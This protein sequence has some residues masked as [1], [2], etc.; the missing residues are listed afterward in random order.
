MPSLKLLAAGDGPASNWASRIVMSE[1]IEIAETIVACGCE[2]D[3]NHYGILDPDSDEPLVIAV[4]ALDPTGVTRRWNGSG[5][6]EV[7]HEMDPVGYQFVELDDAMLADALRGVTAG[8]LLLRATTPKAKTHGVLVAAPTEG[9]H[10]AIVD[11]FDTTAV[12]DLIEVRPGPVTFVRHGGEWVE[13][14]KVLGRLQS[15]D[16]PRIVQIAPDMLAAVVAQVDEFDRANDDAITAAVWEE[17]KYKRSETGQ[18]AKKDGGSADGTRPSM[19]AE[20]LREY[21]RTGKIP[22]DVK[23]AKSLQESAKTKKLNIGGGKVEKAKGGSGGSGGGGKGKGKGGAGGKATGAE[24]AKKAAK[25]GALEGS[26]KAAAAKKVADAVAKKKADA[27]KKARVDLRN[28]WAAEDAKAKAKD[29]AYDIAREKADLAESQRRDATNA[30][31]KAEQAAL[32]E[33]I[34][35]GRPKMT[36]RPEDEAI[37]KAYDRAAMA[38]AT[39]FRNRAN[40][41]LERRTKYDQAAK[42]EAKSE[43]IRRMERRAATDARRAIEKRKLDELDN[44]AGVGARIRA[45]KKVVPKPRAVKAAGVPEHSAMPNK[46]KDYWVRGKGAALIRWGVGGDFNRCR[47]QL[48]KYLNPAQVPG[49]CANLHKAATGTWPGKNRGHGVTAAGTEGPTHAGVAVVAADTGRVLMLQRSFKDE[50]DPARG[51]WEFPGGTIEDGEVPLEAARREWSEETG[52]EFPPELAHVG[53]WDSP[54]GVY[55]GFVVKVPSEDALPVNSGE[56]RVLNPDDP[57]GDDIETAAWWEPEDIPDNPALRPEVK[58]TDWSLLKKAAV[59]AAGYS[60]NG[61]MIALAIEPRLAIEL[62]TPV[63]DGNPSNEMH[64]TL[65]YLGENVDSAILQVAVEIAKEITLEYNAF[66]ATLGGRGQFLNDD[67]ANYISVDAPGIEAFWADLTDRL[68]RAG[69]P[70]PT[71]HGFTPHITLKYGAMSEEEWPSLPQ[72]TMLG[73]IKVC[74]GSTDLG[75]WDMLP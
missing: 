53:S 57:D 45:K 33:K 32:T 67:V 12:L 1:A 18:F 20:Q 41:E 30:A 68:H 8:G 70:L 73:K 21:I 56:S 17:S 63:R 19:N 26:K 29:A 47:K 75:A 16:P 44:A 13:D 38:Q 22:S 54:N 74:S 39:E 2:E 66:P 27:R 42:Y 48:S 15:V 71:E 7:P 40:A 51:T 6:D 34:R 5:W 3:V 46:L 14:R 43:K 9:K 35:T 52:M 55:R 60:G 23:L 59:T 31:L 10:F 24:A 61:S 58:D 36:G 62:A 69:V 25:A 72:K 65:A 4:V 28:K 37:Q 11:D 50:E 49:A 64:V